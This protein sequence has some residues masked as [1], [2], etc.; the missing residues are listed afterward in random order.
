MFSLSRRKGPELWSSGVSS[1]WIGPA[2]GTTALSNYDVRVVASCGEEACG[3]TYH[4]SQVYA[5]RSLVY[6]LGMN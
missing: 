3:S 1:T 2:L 5:A 4:L 6:E